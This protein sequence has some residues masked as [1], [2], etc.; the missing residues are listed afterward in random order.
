MFYTYQSNCLKTICILRFRDCSWRTG[1]RLSTVGIW[2]M[3][4][5]VIVCA[6]FFLWAS[7]WFCYF[8]VRGLWYL[9]LLV[10]FLLTLDSLTTRLLRSAPSSA[11]CYVL[12]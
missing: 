3:L 4:F 11:A 7:D 9:S 6:F 1:S 12:P 10:D 8:L 5:V 2:S